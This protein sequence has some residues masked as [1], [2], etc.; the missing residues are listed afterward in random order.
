M[1][2]LQCV[3]WQCRMEVHIPEKQSNI[4]YIPEAPVITYFRQSIQRESRVRTTAK[5]ENTCV[6]FWKLFK[7]VLIGQCSTT[8]LAMSSA[9]L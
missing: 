4:H 3:S 6:S 1:G 2:S 9:T 5:L 7:C 8:H